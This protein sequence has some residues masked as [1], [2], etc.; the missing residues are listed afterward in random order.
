MN[1]LQ[2][3]GNHNELWQRICVKHI[4]IN[5][6]GEYQDN[7]NYQDIGHNSGQIVFGIPFV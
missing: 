6:T 5:E 4:I 7:Q 1:H 3:D 2:S